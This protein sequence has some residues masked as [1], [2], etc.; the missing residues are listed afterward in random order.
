M[1][2]FLGDLQELDLGIEKVLILDNI[3]R[4]EMSFVPS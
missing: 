1:L 3:A 2:I 4:F